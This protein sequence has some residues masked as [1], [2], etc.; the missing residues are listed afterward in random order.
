[1]HSFLREGSTN[2]KA[3]TEAIKRER[4]RL[5]RVLRRL[6]GV[7]LVSCGEF[8]VSARNVLIEATKSARDGATR[9]DKDV[10]TKRDGSLVTEIDQQIESLLVTRFKRDFPNAAVLGE[11]GAIDTLGMSAE[12][13]YGEF[14]SAPYQITI[15]P[16]DGTRNFIS[17]HPQYCIAVGL[18]VRIKDG[19]WPIAGAIAIPEEGQMFWSDDYRVVVEDLKTGQQ[20]LFSGSSAAADS[21][22]VNSRDRAWLAANGIELRLPWVSS[23][24]SVYDFLGTVVGRHRGS[25]IG[26]QRLWDL[27]AP[28]AIALRA[29]LVL[30]D[31]ES[32]S[33][34]GSISCQDLS[35]DIVSRPWG[36]GRK[37]V[38]AG[39]G[40]NIAEL[41]KRFTTV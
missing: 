9:R 24:S 19:V 13:V 38:L 35:K 33:V 11:E 2:R 23:G 28:L 40:T 26:S 32:G 12:E 22:S 10:Q 21:V 29:G 15:D 27:M 3:N 4:E 7:Q 18:S 17:G 39:R 6:R 20:S 37:M 5:Q 34:I 8:V 14:F 41:V 36:L 1:M 31:L 16:I 25:I 30:R